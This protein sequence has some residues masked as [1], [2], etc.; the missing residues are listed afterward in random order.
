MFFAA[1]LVQFLNIWH[2]LS[3]KP[4][5][6]RLLFKIIMF[7][8]EFVSTLGLLYKS[9]TEE[10]CDCQLKAPNAQNK[11]GSETENYFYYL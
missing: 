7:V 2:V 1:L 5:P 4:K 9:F 11:A 6:L 10:N 8:L 3:S